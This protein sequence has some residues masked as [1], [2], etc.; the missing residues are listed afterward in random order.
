MIREITIRAV[1][2]GFIVTVGCQTIV[3]DKI[4][5][6]VGALNDYLMDPMRTEKRWLD[7][8]INAKYTLRGEPQPATV[9]TDSE[10]YRAGRNEAQPARNAYDFLH[11]ADGGAGPTQ[12]QTHEGGPSTRRS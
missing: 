12:G 3:F 9:A 4:E 11:Y 1:M 6:L 7:T 2:N 10:V 8:A 5:H